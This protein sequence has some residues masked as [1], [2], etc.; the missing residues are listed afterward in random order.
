MRCLR[1]PY[2]QAAPFPKAH[3]S[4]QVPSKLF[5]TS[6]INSWAKMI[7]WVKHFKLDLAQRCQFDSPDPKNNE[8]ISVFSPDQGVTI[9]RDKLAGTN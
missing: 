8:A 2:V 4:I 1:G 6:P 5:Q 3:S 7:S 9:H